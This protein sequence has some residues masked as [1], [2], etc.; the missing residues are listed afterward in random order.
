MGTLGGGARTV[1]FGVTSVRRAAC[2]TT[3]PRLKEG[4]RPM[5]AGLFKIAAVVVVL[6]LLGLVLLC[7][8]GLAVGSANA[9]ILQGT[10]SDGWH[11]VWD[12]WVQ[13][14]GWSLIFLAVWRGARR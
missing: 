14:L 4:E 9:W 10:F 1:T 5:I 12:R 13:S 11:A 2:V 6:F 3:T 7:W 8:I